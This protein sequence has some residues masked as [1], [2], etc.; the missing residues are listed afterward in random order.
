MST[1]SPSLHL[2]IGK[3]RFLKKELIESLKA[4]WFPPGHDARLN[5]QEF[6]AKDCS[7]SEVMDFVNTAPFL[8][9]RRL[10]VVWGVDLFDKNE[11]EIFLDAI[12]KCSPT[13]LLVLESEETN[14][15][16]D[17]FLKKLSVTA[18]LTACHRPFERDLP[19]WA[20]LRAR[21][22]GLS[23]ERRATLFLIACCG[24][25]LSTLASN[26]E[27]LAVFVH[28]KTSASL[29]E[30]QHLFQKRPDDDVFGL[31]DLLLE[32]KHAEA[33]RVLDTLF[34][35]GAR[36]PEIVASLATQIERWTKGVLR[37]AEGA[38]PDEIGRELKIPPFFQGPFFARLKNLPMAKL[39]KL[40]QSLLNCDEN[41]KSGL[42]TERL[43]L[44]GFIWTS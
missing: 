23:L 27:Q 28:P 32:G 37:L 15:N 17:A 1:G 41:F 12:E 39:K 14:A 29:T 2:L 13:G 18:K 25:E 19:G 35:E 40:T 26:I 11:R 7:V 44:E 31:A 10:A 33:L 36:G 22:C 4:Q 9:E 3:E 42:A 6:H 20:E 24:G 16:K 21:K 43:A 34:R 30:A 38:K 5:A 8:A